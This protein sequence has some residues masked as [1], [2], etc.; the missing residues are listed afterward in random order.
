MLSFSYRDRHT[1][2][3]I[4]SVFIMKLL[5]TDVVLAACHDENIPELRD[6][7]KEGARILVERVE[8]GDAVYDY[9]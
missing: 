8:R 4:V 7:S 2:P 6:L 5:V 1:N 3:H 9:R